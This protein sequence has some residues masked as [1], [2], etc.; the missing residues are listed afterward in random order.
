MEENDKRHD[1]KCSGSTCTKKTKKSRKKEDNLVKAGQGTVKEF[2]LQMMSNWS[3]KD[4]K[5]W[6]V[7]LINCLPVGKA[8]AVTG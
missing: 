3:D 8:C 1:E 7:F 6:G 2:P 4:Q 5:D